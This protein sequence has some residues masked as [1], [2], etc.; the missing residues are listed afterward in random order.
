MA[1]DAD[2]RMVLSSR[3]KLKAEIPLHKSGVS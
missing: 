1:V 2:R 3:L